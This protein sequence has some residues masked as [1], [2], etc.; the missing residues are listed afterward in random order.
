MDHVPLPEAPAPK[1]Q[2]V[3]D[4]VAAAIVKF[5][6]GLFEHMG[7]AATPVVTREGDTYQFPAPGGGGTGSGSSGAS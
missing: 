4:D 7:V 2:P 5:Q 1:A 6:T 3:D